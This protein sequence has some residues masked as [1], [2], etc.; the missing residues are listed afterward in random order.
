[1]TEE[2]IMRMG[3]RAG[4]VVVACVWLWCG[5]GEAAA[6][7]CGDADG[8]GS[9]TVTD[10]VQALRAAAGLSTSCAAGRCDVDGSG[11]ITITDGVNVL[12]KAAGLTI[13]EAC[14][15]G[16]TTASVQAFLGEMTKIARIPSSAGLARLA[17][18]NEVT[19]PCEEGFIELAGAK[20]TY[21]NCR[22]GTLVIN[23]AI[24][25]TNV[26]SDP[27][28]GRFVR[29]DLYEQYEVHFLD[30]GF[31]FRQD[32]TS[33]LD[34][35]TKAKKLIE[36]GT[37][38]IFT[39]QSALGQD[40]YT[41][42]KKDLT[43]DTETGTVVSGDLIS[44]LAEAGVADIKAVTLG[45]VTGTVADVDVEFDDGHF[46]AFKY[47]ITSGELTSA[48]L[49]AV[50]AWPRRRAGEEGEPPRRSRIG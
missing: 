4:R 31:T 8:S 22:F 26:L 25:T 33:R 40:E 34:I 48:S 5:V 3:R 6:Q 9:V 21:V 35:D 13:A 20:S 45:F 49:A 30:T 10:G 23:G 39:S 44:A 1:M 50:G 2:D 19:T 17:I 43:T 38:T 7:V 14:T 27:E 12:R 46:E 36:N 29:S 18:A 32:G 11:S 47:D 37:L 42:T 16:S 15:G 41:L 28:N 24:T